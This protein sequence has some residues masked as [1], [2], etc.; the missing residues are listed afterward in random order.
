MDTKK[1]FVQKLEA[2][3]QTN[4]LHGESQH[5]NHWFEVFENQA[6][7]QRYKTAYFNEGKN[8]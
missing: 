5:Y 1:V 4:Q 6:K 3:N 7:R 8:V 2:M